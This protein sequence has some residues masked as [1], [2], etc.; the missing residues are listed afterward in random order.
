EVR[1]HRPVEAVDGHQ[2]LERADAVEVR[3]GQVPG[4]GG[5]EMVARHVILVTVAVEDMVGWR[6]TAGT[7]HQGERGVD[8]HRLLASGH[9]QRAALRIL[10]AEPAAE[11]RDVRAER[12]IRF[13]HRAPAMSSMM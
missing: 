12:A 2:A 5:I 10:S 6:R 4:G 1:G 9:E 8:D 13:A 11:E 7:C 3:L